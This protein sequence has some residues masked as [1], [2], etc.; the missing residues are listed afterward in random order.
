MAP[1]FQ[2]VLQPRF[3]GHGQ[4]MGN[5]QAAGYP[6]GWD[7]CLKSPG[8]ARGLEDLLAGLREFCD[9]VSPAPGNVVQVLYD[10]ISSQVLEGLL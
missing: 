6:T 10:I 8:R 5:L 1:S 3:G 2:T 7:Q 9:R 4:R